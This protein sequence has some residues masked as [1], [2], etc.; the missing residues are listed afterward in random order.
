M[1]GG[2]SDLVEQERMRLRRLTRLFN[3]SPL[4]FITACTHERQP[5]LANTDV[6]EAFCSFAE[7]GAER[8]AWVGR[9]VIMPDHLHLFVA[10]DAPLELSMWM[11]SLKNLLSKALR[12]RGITSPHWQ[13]GF[14]DHVLRSS[15]SYGEKW[16]YVA[17]N[18]ER[19]GLVMPGDEW[20]YA[21][22]IHPLRWQGRE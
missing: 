7:E 20:A 3:G 10:I 22:E 8:G 15:E 16:R 12:Q 9:Y 19:A 5:F 18:P 17:E 21:G 2:E 11:K 13:K 6:H 14:F 1:S 4:Y